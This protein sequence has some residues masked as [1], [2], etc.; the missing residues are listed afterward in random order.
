MRRAG[1][2]TLVVALVPGTARAHAFGSY[3]SAYQNFLEGA[4]VF[5]ASPGLLLPV[6]SV[7]LVLGLWRAEGLLAA[8]G[9]ILAATLLGQGLALVAGP[10]VA[11]VPLALGVVVAV[12]G[13]LVPLKR[14]ATALPVL[15]SLVALAVSAGALEGHGWGEVALATRLGILFGLHFVL[16]AAA[17]IVRISRDTFPHH[18]TDILWRV[19]SSWLAAILVLYLAFTLRGG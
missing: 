17:A 8:W 4:A 15:A 9:P 7:A 10:W 18:T 19:V 16:A 2:A 11:S 1:S 13:A 3:D 14:I 5:L 12:L 6:L